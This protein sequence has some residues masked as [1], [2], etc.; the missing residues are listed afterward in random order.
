MKQIPST[1]SFIE[2]G[3][4]PTTAE[5]GRFAVSPTNQRRGA[6]SML[7]EAA[8]AHARA[9]R[10]RVLIVRTSDFNKAA[11]RMYVKKGWVVEKKMAYPGYSNLWRF[12]IV[13]RKNLVYNKT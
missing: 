1:H 7:M 9:H 11:I 13:F 4:D 12:V 10:L 6:G 3:S 2:V 5:V 8:I